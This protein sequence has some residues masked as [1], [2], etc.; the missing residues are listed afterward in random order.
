MRLDA[1]RLALVVAALC[2]AGGLLFLAHGWLTR[3]FGRVEAELVYQASRL[4]R[5][6]PLYVDPAVGVSDMGPPPSRYYVL[7]TPFWPW[8]LA[9]LSPATLVGVRSVGRALNGLLFLG[10][11]GAVVRASRPGNRR[12][13]LTG[14][15]LAVGL[16]MLV[17]E[18]GTADADMAAVALSTLGLLRMNQRRGLDA[19][20]AALLAAAPLVKPSVL[21]TPVGAVVAHVVTHW[22]SGP[23]RL[24]AP[25]LVGGLVAG[26]LAGVCH[27]WSHGEWLSH[28]ARATGQTLSFDRW[29]Q[30]FGGRFMFLGLPHVVVGVFAVRRRAPRVATLPLA[31]SVAWSVFSMAK[32]GSGTQYWLEPTMAALVVLGACPPAAAPS[33]AGAWAAWAGLVLAVAV[34]ATSFPELVR[35]AR[36]ETRWNAVVEKLR[37]HCTL[38]PGEV[39][40]S[41]DTTLELELDGR[42]IVPSWQTSYLVRTGKFPLEAWR[43]DL[44]GR[45]G[46]R[47]FI[48]SEDYL[49][50]PPERI[51]GATEVSAFRKELR[52]VM[53]ATFTFDSEIDGMLVYKRR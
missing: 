12:A 2:A 3:P 22:R 50:P 45:D 31:T 7:Y 15:L 39:I 49:E 24:L 10:T 19:L 34:G 46:P 36:E 13:V 51:E 20:S 32:H 6:L 28:I 38:R 27:V 29:L 16:A 5:G 25:L 26:A 44:A 42:V 53:E 37:A 18:V 30:E 8:L 9:K 41:S 17:R 21:G 48:H 35:A 4:Q 23:R 47:W 43:R 11:L 52:D 1:R 14:A 40:V 33:R